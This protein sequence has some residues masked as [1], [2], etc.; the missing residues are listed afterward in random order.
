MQ[1]TTTKA[2]SLSE[3]LI[4]SR[5]RGAPTACAEEGLTLQLEGRRLDS[6]LVG[7]AGQVRG[8]LDGLWGSDSTVRGHTG[9]AN[10]CANPR[11]CREP[12]GPP[13]RGRG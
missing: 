13:E 9:H 6:R 1:T 11:R 2:T 4:G 5:L 3:A 12:T 10:Q 7:E 8:S